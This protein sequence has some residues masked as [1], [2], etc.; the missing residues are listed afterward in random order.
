MKNI[1]K[2]LIVVLFSFLSLNF[3]LAEKSTDN[4]VK[5]NLLDLQFHKKLDKLENVVFG[6]ICNKGKGN[7]PAKIETS[8]LI[9]GKTIISKMFTASLDAEGYVEQYIV[10]SQPLEEQSCLQIIFQLPSDFIDGTYTAVFTPNTNNVIAEYDGNTNQV[11]ADIKVFGM[12]SVDNEF[13]EEEQEEDISKKIIQDLSVKTSKKSITVNISK[14][15]ALDAEHEFYFSCSLG[16]KYSMGH[17]NKQRSKKHKITIS[18]LKEKS[19][20]SCF[21]A[22]VDSENSQKYPEF[23]H[24]SQSKIFFTKTINANPGMLL[25]EQEFYGN[26]PKTNGMG[27][28]I[29]GEFIPNTE[30]NTVLLTLSKNNNPFPDTDPNSIEGLAAAELFRRHVLKGYPN[31]EFQGENSVNRAEAEFFLWYSQVGKHRKTNFIR[32]DSEEYLEISHYREGRKSFIDINED[33]WFY[34]IILVVADEKIISGF[35]DQTFQPYSNVTV[36]QFA[37]ML[38]L[39]FEIPVIE[40]EGRWSE[41]YFS[42]LEKYNL[43]L[44]DLPVKKDMTR[45]EVAV[46]IYQFLKKYDEFN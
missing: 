44:L 2:I 27:Y 21:I 22:L 12:N 37:K 40:K 10:S 16:N 24:N 45:N 29:E 39:T 15:Y 9:D 38:T 43:D 19:F 11:T 32:P 28:P 3:S 20:F 6:N 18:N 26:K 17:V 35:S 13:L 30:K 33:D 46:A 36:E 42:A 23:I 25:W 5:I 14:N 8:M 1:K 41:K 34:D 4:S 31:G 7:I